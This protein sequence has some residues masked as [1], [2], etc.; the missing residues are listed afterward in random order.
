[1]TQ[2]RKMHEVQL[3]DD[4]PLGEFQEIKSGSP[5]QLRII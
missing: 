2:L 5:R 4:E 1:M 3:H